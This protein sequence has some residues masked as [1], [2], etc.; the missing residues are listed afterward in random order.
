MKSTARK[1][2]SQE[3]TRTCRNSEGTR[4]EMEKVRRE[5]MQVREKVGKSPNTV[6]FQCFVASEGRK[7]GSLSRR[8]PSHLARWK[9]ENCTPLW[10]EAHFEVKMY[11][12]PHARTT[13]GSWDVEKAHPVV[14]WSTLRS[15][16]VKTPQPRSTFYP[17]LQLINPGV[18]IK[19]P[20]G[21]NFCFFFIIFSIWFSIR[22]IEK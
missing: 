11:K 19:P 18:I 16:S 22:P 5:K 12:T 20:G 3:E 4:S 2:Q 7:V 15:K 21:V 13:F 8:V 6:F 14:A 17:F 1:K 9:M 10:R